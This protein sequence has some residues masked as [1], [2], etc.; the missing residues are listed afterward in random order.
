MKRSMCTLR[1]QVQCDGRPWP[2]MHKRMQCLTNQGRCSSFTP[3]AGTI[4]CTRAFVNLKS[5]QT[6]GPGITTAQ[7][8][9]NRSTSSL[10]S[11]HPSKP[12]LVLGV[13]AEHA[14]CP[15]GQPELARVRQ[16]ANRGAQADKLVTRNLH[17]STKTR[18][19]VLAEQ[20]DEKQTQQH[21]VGYMLSSLAHS[22]ICAAT[23][24]TLVAFFISASLT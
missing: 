16:L 11:E 2:S 12:H 6:A 19:R 9:T 23:A 10:T 8:C 18:R 14:Q 4:T 20:Q 1:C 22:N 5:A 24:L 13:S 21:L 3:A 15:Y 17:P 7:L